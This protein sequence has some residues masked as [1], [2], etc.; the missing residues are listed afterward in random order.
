MSG[1]T[2]VGLF[3]ALLALMFA[4]AV[5]AGSV[6]DPDPGEAT[7]SDERMGS[8][9]APADGAAHAADGETAA[10][11]HSTSGAARAKGLA[12]AE[13]GLR[14]V[15]DDAARPAGSQPLRFRIVRQNGTTVRAFD[16][17]HARRM[18]LIVVRRDLSG[19]QHLHPEQTPG[20]GWEVP[21]RLAEAGSY[22]VFAD[23]SSRGESHTLGSDL[24]VDGT[25]DARELPHPESTAVTESG[26]EVRL[27]DSGGDV[28]FR[29]FEDGR[30]VRDIEP[31]L[32]ARGHLVALREGDLAYLHV[33][34]ESEAT[35][36]SDIRFGVEYPS[37]GRYRLFLQF[38]LDGQIHTAAFTR[39]VGDKH[40]H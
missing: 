34:P 33:H 38:K 27:D 39:E 18:H 6:L 12:Q 7:E 26:Y 22:R 9:H 17:E 31:Y 2:R 15:L 1:L 16:V 5:L 21:L 24:H 40:G 4:G 30:Q 14:L 29:V 25:F 32:D 37:E 13:D 28:R 8:A 11:T 23:F 36:G 35:Q 10:G 3:G 19:F 20:G